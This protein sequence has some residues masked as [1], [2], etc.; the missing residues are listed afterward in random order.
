MGPVISN[1]FLDSTN[2]SGTHS[3][4]L[5][6]PRDLCRIA[7][8]NSSCNEEIERGYPYNPTVDSPAAASPALRAPASTSRVQDLKAGIAMKSPTTSPN[9]P[10]STPKLHP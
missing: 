2:T 4:H 5:Q 1:G 9:P 10:S 8:A 3:H 6:P 7:R